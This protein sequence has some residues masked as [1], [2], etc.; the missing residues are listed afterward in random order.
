[1]KV[2]FL[3][4]ALETGELDFFKI[5]AIEN[6]ELI[7]LSKKKA[8]NC[9]KVTPKEK[10][11]LKML[12][13][14]G[15]PMDKNL[16]LLKELLDLVEVDLTNENQGNDDDQDDNTSD[17]ELKSISFK[18]I[19]VPQ[20]DAV[21]V[22]MNSD[23]PHLDLGPK[24]FK[25]LE[26]DTFEEEK[27]HEESEEDDVNFHE[28]PT[29]EPPKGYD[30]MDKRTRQEL[31]E[32]MYLKRRQQKLQG[33]WNVKLTNYTKLLFS[34]PLGKSEEGF[35]KKSL[36]VKNDMT[37]ENV[38]R[39]SSNFSFFSDKV[40]QDKRKPALLTGLKIEATENDFTKGDDASNYLN[41]ETPNYGVDND[42][43]TY[44]MKPKTTPKQ[45]QRES[46]KPKEFVFSHQNPAKSPVYQKKDFQIPTPTISQAMNPIKPMVSP[47]NINNYNEM[48]FFN[49]QTPVRAHNRPFNV[50]SRG[51]GHIN[52][53]RNFA[54]IF[55]ND[56]GRNNDYSDGARTDNDN[57]R[58]KEPLNV[59]N[60]LL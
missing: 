37:F 13:G 56:E 21:Q 46:P 27:K 36:D 14:T 17:Q 55:G 8:G 49:I 3:T 12:D 1:M 58:N 4:D 19:S 40:K 23:T 24:R 41:Q 48:M 10:R 25:A 16:Q 18:N 9:T 31:Y 32:R 60:G 26:I 50:F 54:K 57:S 6:K 15:K 44:N 53:L 34:T 2:N 35:D 52:P 29:N 30:L 59:S 38:K 11:V 42:V 7:N 33:K 47:S 28:I 51:H 45:K 43:F 5:R 22:P 39:C 20:I